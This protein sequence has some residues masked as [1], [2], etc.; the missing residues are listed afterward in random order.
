ML[1]SP[2]LPLL[3]SALSGTIDLLGADP[4]ATYFRQVGASGKELLTRLR[5]ALVTLRRELGPRLR[6]HARSGGGGWGS[7]D[8]VGVRLEMLRDNLPGFLKYIRTLE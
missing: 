7:G 3:A 4:A 8:E 6:A 5:A 2:S 1:Q